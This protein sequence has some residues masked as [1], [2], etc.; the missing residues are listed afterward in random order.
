MMYH[1]WNF[2]CNPTHLTSRRTY[3]RTMEKNKEKKE[4]KKRE[5]CE[6]NLVAPYFT[7]MLQRLSTNKLTE[8]TVRQ[9]KCFPS[10]L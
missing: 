6:L 7:L 2:P 8:L 1:I 4:R 5:R 9:S 10:K 3:S